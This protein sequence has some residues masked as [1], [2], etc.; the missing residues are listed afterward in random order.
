M[1]PL[2]RGGRGHFICPD[3]IYHYAEIKEFSAGIVARHWE[4]LLPIACP[5]LLPPAIRL[6]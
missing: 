3:K 1:H 2:P 4:E 6:E 5:V